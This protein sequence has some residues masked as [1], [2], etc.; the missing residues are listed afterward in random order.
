MVVVKNLSRTHLYVSF[1]IICL[2]LFFLF[3]LHGYFLDDI[4]LQ[5]K[6]KYT[7]HN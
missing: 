1:K 5:L 7:Q 6:V 2:F 3:S 4:V